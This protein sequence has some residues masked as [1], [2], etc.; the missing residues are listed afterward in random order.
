MAELNHKQQLFVEAYLGVA[1]GNATEAARIA[2]YKQPHSQGPRLLE[3]VEIASRV[4]ARVDDAAM[5]AD[6]VLSE[7]AA[8]AR[9]KWDADPKAV[10]NKVR[11]LELLGKHHKLFTEKQEVEHS[12]TVNGMTPT[13]NVYAS[14][15][16]QPD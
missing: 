4:A 9:I 12:G 14:E 6:A 10:Q 15:S 16:K 8:V 11:A 1:N 2:G 13:I 5:T 3:N 7:L